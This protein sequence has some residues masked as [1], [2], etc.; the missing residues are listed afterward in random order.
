[1]TEYTVPFIQFDDYELSEFE[2]WEYWNEIE[3]G[4]QR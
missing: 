3:M 4:V 1:M 2:A